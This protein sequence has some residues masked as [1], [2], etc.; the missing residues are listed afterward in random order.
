MSRVYQILVLALFGAVWFVGSLLTNSLIPSPNDAI[1]A[2]LEILSNGK[3]ALGFLNSLYRYA[4]GL[5]IGVVLGVTSGFLLGLNHTILKAFDPLINLLRPI[6]PIAWMPI[7]VIIFGLGNKPSIFIIAYAVFFPIMLITIK[8]IND[9]SKDLIMM[10]RNFGASRWQVLKGVIYP[11]SFFDI[12]SGLKLVASLAW[13]N[14]V[15]GEMAGAQTGLGYMIIDARNQLRTDI[16]IAVIITIG[17]VGYAIN[18]VFL[19]FEKRIA[20][21]FGL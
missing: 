7:V 10:A 3:L 9:V 21:R 1:L 16:V 17:A 6:S 12:A 13:I 20:K 4:L 8:A 11:S 14:L 18:L 19:W 2:F 5:V 15:V